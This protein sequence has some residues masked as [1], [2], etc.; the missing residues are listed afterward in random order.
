MLAKYNQKASYKKITKSTDIHKVYMN[1]NQGKD[2]IM[3]ND[4]EMI[5]KSRVVED[6]TKRSLKKL[7]K[8]DVIINP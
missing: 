3:V 1:Y 2:Y 4:T 5:K 6:P 7:R 8:S